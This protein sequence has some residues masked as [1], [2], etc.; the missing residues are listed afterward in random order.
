MPHSR[1]FMNLEMIL[2]NG[3]R[4]LKLKDLYC[5]E[6]QQLLSNSHLEYCHLNCSWAFCEHL[7]LYTRVFSLSHSKEKVS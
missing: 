1:R 2:Q 7:V 6:M 3:V 4:Y 5:A